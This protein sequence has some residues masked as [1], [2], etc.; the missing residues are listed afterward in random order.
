MLHYYP[1]YVSSINM[2][3]FRRKNCVHTASGI[4]A[5]CKR[6]HSTPVESRVGSQPVY[7]LSVVSIDFSAT[8]YRTEGRPPEKVTKFTNLSWSRIWR[9]STVCNIISR[10]LCRFCTLKI[11][12][13]GESWGYAYVN[14]I[15][16]Y[17]QSFYRPKEKL[18]YKFYH[19]FPRISKLICKY[20]YNTY[21][22]HWD[23]NPKCSCI[24]IFSVSAILMMTIY[25][26][27]M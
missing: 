1:R 10:I 5:L 18:Y 25:F 15:V 27:N 16:F 3:I 20:L 23:L 9:K 24:I 4:V 21:V 14:L 13:K 22:K 17:T 6:L 19:F 11:W 26:W 8:L 2:S 12:G 7:L